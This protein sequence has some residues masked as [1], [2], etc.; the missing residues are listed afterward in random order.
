MAAKQRFWT[1]HDLKSDPCKSWRG[2][3]CTAG[4]GSSCWTQQT[5]GLEDRGFSES[6]LWPARAQCCTG[7]NLEVEGMGAQATQANGQLLKAS[8]YQLWRHYR[9]DLNQ[10]RWSD[11]PLNSEFAAGRASC[12][13]RSDDCRSSRIKDK[14]WLPDTTEGELWACSGENWWEPQVAFRIF[15]VC[16]SVLWRKKHYFWQQVLSS[17]RTE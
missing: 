8:V 5:E 10:K 15:A 1:L 7:H 4:T 3:V 13:E 6:G 17:M 12:P 2:Q 11:V 16:I 14:A 9:S